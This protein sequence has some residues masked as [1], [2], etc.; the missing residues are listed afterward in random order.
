VLARAETVLCAAPLVVSLD[1]GA[2]VRP[3]AG[4]GSVEHLVAL[5]AASL[6][7]TPDRRWLA[8]G[9]GMR[10][11]GLPV[12]I[13]RPV[14]QRFAALVRHERVRESRQEPYVAGQ[15]GRLMANIRTVPAGSSRDSYLPLLRLADGSEAQVR[16]YYQAGDLYALDGDGRPLG[17]VLA[18][19]EPGLRARGVRHVIVGT[20]SSG[21]GQLAFYQKCGF[22]V[23]R[24]ERD[25]FGAARGYPPG[26]EENGNRCAT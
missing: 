19:A 10:G 9:E 25:F 8:E 5:V 21:M 22:R 6:L 26:L 1:G 3:A 16:G 4:D 18:I 13:R 24:I 20:T 12:G 14:A 15:A 7:S 11:A 17:V 2:R 23:W